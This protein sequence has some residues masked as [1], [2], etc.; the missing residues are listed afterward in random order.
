MATRDVCVNEVFDSGPITPFQIRVF[1]LCICVTLFD[2]FDLM[3]IG[4]ALPKIAQFLHAGPSALGLAVGAGQLGPLVGAITLGM[5]A[6]RFG[7]KRTLILS[8]IIFGIF[9]L[10]T[11]TITSVEQLALFRFLSGVG[12]GGAIPNALSFGCEYAPTRKRAS[13]TTLMWSGMAIGSIAAGFV[14][15]WLLPHHGWQ[16]LFWVGGIPPLVIAVLVALFLPESLAFL[17]RQGTD[18]P[19]IH[20]IV[21]KISPRLAADKD[22]EFYSAEKKLAGVPVIHLFTEGRAFTTVSIWILFFLSF[23]LMWVMLAWTPTLL[24][25]SG[26]T[27]QQGSL[28]FAFLNVGSLVATLTIGVLMDRFDSYRTVAGT[29]VLAFITVGAF[30]MMVG[31]SFMMI[32]VMAVVTGV[33]IFGANAGMMALCTVSYPVSMRGSGVGWAYG[34][35]KVGSMVG[36]IVGGLLLSRN[37]SVTRICVVNGLSGVVAAIVVMILKRHVD[38]ARRRKAVPETVSVA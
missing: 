38:A 1:I 22:V 9:T 12:L 20:K 10:L 24:H 17:V 25:R 33:F 31:G 5:L 11:T 18:K 21:S 6:D 16:I 3:V 32:A 23:F 34:F 14:A 36:P 2:G 27:G 19:R 35:G 37:W 13:F 29:F 28:V 7:R 30:G 15:A 26:A 8:A 4:V